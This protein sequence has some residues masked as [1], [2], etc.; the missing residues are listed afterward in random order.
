[1]Y[2][3]SG[4][5]QGLS[6]LVIVSPTR[7]SFTFL[8]L[9][10]IYPTMPALSSSHGIN[11]PAPKYPTSTTFAVA[12]VAIIFIFIPAFTTPCFK[13]QKTI[14]PLYASYK[15]SNINA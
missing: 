13:R 1:M 9:A 10:V 12:P 2:P 14:T 5:A 7:V 3:G 4:S 15:L 6:A 8:M 11:C